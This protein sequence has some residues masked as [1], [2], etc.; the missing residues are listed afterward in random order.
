VRFVR[1]PQMNQEKLTSIGFIPSSL[2][3]LTQATLPTV[4]SKLL[5]TIAPVKFSAYDAYKLENIACNIPLHITTDD[6]TLMLNPTPLAMGTYGI[7]FIDISNTYIIKYIP[8]HDAVQP[9]SEIIE[10]YIHASV[11]HVLAKSNLPKTIPSLK[12]II[13]TDDAIGFVMDYVHGRKATAFL[14]ESMYFVPPYTN[15]AESIVQTN[16]YIIMTFLAQI[17]ATLRILQTEI[18][19][20]HRDFYGENIIMSK[21]TTD[22]SGQVCID[23]A[24]INVPLLSGCWPQ[25]IDM[26]F[27]RIKCPTA[28]VIGTFSMLRDKKQPSFSEGRDICHLVIYILVYIIGLNPTNR[29]GK[30]PISEGLR[31]WLRQIVT[32]HIDALDETYCLAKGINIYDPHLKQRIIFDPSL[33]ASHKRG[34]ENLYHVLNIDYI[35]LPDATPTA[36]L[37]KYA[38][39]FC[40]TK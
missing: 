9:A 31:D 40:K 3:F 35:R 16:D 1:L 8:I 27:A 17:A 6:A 11:E 30:Y 22:Y 38:E 25:L 14:R 37:K 2:W 7:I 10:A 20:N 29:R 18:K 21:V 5:E 39:S 33:D 13:A 4:R 28:G 19:F 15:A 12:R 32:I 26:G 24:T 34:W 23:G 36:V